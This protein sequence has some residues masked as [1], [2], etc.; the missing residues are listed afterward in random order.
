MTRE[1]FLP[2]GA[3]MMHTDGVFPLTQDSVLLAGFVR[4]K[5]KAKV[6]DLGTGAAT[7][8][9]MLLAKH[10]SITVDG[11][12]ICERSAALAAQN[13]ERNGFVDRGAVMNVD[14][15]TLPGDMADKY[16][17]CVSN[18]PYYDTS[19]GAVSQ[20]YAGARSEQSCTA[21][22]LCAAA[23]RALRWGGVFCL[24]YP[25][26]RLSTLMQALTQSRLEPKRMQLVHDRLDKSATLVLIEAKKGG[27]EGLVTL[28][29]LIVRDQTGQYTAEFEQNYV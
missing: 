29:P 16:D 12:E 24:C 2:G 4:V 23:S 6:I 18:P 26:D 17:I 15:R 14:M 28:P 19:R 5:K 10:E 13:Y 21:G 11:I 27:G 3:T 20:S 8:P 1:L 9:L 25:A 7:L 22:D